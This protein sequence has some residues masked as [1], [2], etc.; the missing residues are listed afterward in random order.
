MQGDASLEANRNATINY[1]AELVHVSRYEAAGSDYYPALTPLV[2]KNP[3]AIGICDGGVGDQALIVKQ[4]RELGYTG[5]LI[6][7]NHGDPGVTMEVAGVEAAQGL[8]IN[9]P[10]YSSDIYPE[11]T[12]QLYAEYQELYP[13]AQFG[14]C[15]YL[16]YSAVWFYK[17]AIEKAG[18]IDPDEVL[19]VFDDP[20]WT[21]DWFGMS[22][23]SLGGL[24]L[25]GIRRVNQ[26]EVCF[27]VVK[28][29]G[30]E[31]ISRMATIVP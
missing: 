25:F 27:S 5:I 20:S 24:E 28:G 16:G 23:R 1:G 15:Q 14:L 19:K 6:G 13:G 7:A 8:L 29:E 26:D 18:S 22:G 3:D 17:Q 31:A 30:F 4:V 9:E 10:D 12:R 21:Y 11:T 2:A